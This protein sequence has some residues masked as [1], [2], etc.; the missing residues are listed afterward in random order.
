LTVGHKDD[1]YDVLTMLTLDASARISVIVR[2]CQH[3]AVRDANNYVND[4]CYTVVASK[5][6]LKLILITKLK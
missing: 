4:V 1:S 2:Y 3:S 6:K 5:V